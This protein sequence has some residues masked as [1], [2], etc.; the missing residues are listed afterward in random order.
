M[1]VSE[2]E[3]YLEKFDL[4]LD[5]K[6]KSLPIMY[7]SPK[8]HKSPI[9]FRFIVASK[10]CST[11]PLTEVVS[12]VF[13]MLFNHVES[14]HC[15]SKFYSPF[16]KFWVVQNSFPV[17]NHLNKINAKRKAKSISTFDFSTLYTS[18]PHN[19]LIDVLCN[20]IDFVFQGR[21]KAKIGFSQTSV[22]WT[23]KGTQ[24]RFFNK[25]SLKDAVSLLI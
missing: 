13:K 21:A 8:M 1:T 3:K 25:E 15:K 20:I 11:K 6:S 23:N 22:Y 10:V 19:L 2:N 16:N 9:G 12:R 4:N 5:E 7:M 24:K 17:I 14:F 18:I